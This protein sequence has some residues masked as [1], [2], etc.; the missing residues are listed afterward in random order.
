MFY[1]RMYSVA[2]NFHWSGHCIFSHGKKKYK[3]Y[4]KK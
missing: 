3:I 2:N 4:I 1:S